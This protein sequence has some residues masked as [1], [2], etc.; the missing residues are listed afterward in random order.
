M[1]CDAIARWYEL[2]E[3]FCFGRA[4]ERRR[5]AYLGELQ[6]A[7]RALVCGG[8][9]G[10][11]LAELLRGNAR[12]QVTYVDLSREMMRLAER[13]VARLGPEF[14]ARVEFHCADL[15]T[16]VPPR[17]DFDLFATHF[18]FD[19]F[20]DEQARELALRLQSW[21][22]PRARWVLSE[23][24]QPPPFFARAWTSAVVRALYAGFRLTTGLRVRRIPSCGEALRGAGFQLR[25]RE[26]AA[27]G[28]LISELWDAA[29]NGG[30]G[31]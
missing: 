11:F 26:T 27:G 14:R 31:A 19:C 5:F 23:F 28:L 30:I 2:A 9:D 10:R 13:R 7:R 3:H 18:F 29:Q 1:N 17:A 6:G 22:A 8:G 24:H 21:A 16:F 12:V 4:L 15:R 20:T 25:T